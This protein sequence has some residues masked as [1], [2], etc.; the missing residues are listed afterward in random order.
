MT[1]TYFPKKNNGHCG[2]FLNLTMKLSIIRVT[3]HF[4]YIENMIE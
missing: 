3:N 1:Y 2:F 4:Q